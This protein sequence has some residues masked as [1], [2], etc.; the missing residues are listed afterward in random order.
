[1]SIEEALD[2]IIKAHPYYWKG[3]QRTFFNEKEESGRES[4]VF[5]VWKDGHLIHRI[6]EYQLNRAYDVIRFRHGVPNDD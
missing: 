1:M 2:I 5:C 6:S 4:Q 3:Y